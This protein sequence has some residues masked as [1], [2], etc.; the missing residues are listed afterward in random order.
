MNTLVMQ[1]A[2]AL[3]TNV[4]GGADGILSGFLTPTN[5]TF[6]ILE[7]HALAGLCYTDDGGL[8][9]DLTTEFNEDTDDDVPALP[10][11]PANGDA[12]YF[13]HATKQFTGVDVNLTTDGAGTWTITY[14]YWNGTA[15]TALAGVVDGTSGWVASGT[16]FFS[17]TFTAPTDWEK[18]T[19]D[20]VDG[21]WIRGVVSG[22]SAITTR[23]LV[24][25]GFIIVESANSLFTDDTADLID[26]G[27]G[28]VALLPAFPKLNDAFYISYSSKFCKFEMN[29]ATARTGTATLI[30]EYWNGTVWG[31]IT[32]VIDD[33]AGWSTGTAQYL[34]HFE[35]PSDWVATTAANGP[36]GA[37]GYFVRTRISAFTSV[38]VDPL[39]TQAWVYPLVTGADG[40]Q[41]Q[42]TMTISLINMNAGTISA[43]NNDSKFLLLNVS[44][45]VF[46]PFTWT[47]ADVAE[48]AAISLNVAAN[49]K[50]ALIQIQEDVT[51]EF[52]DG[53]FTLTS[54]N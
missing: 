40:L 22:F 5:P 20:G 34:I 12:T 23:P 10:A 53:I 52:A 6:G 25:Q 27:A 18:N 42:E 47:Q 37:V 21:F 36:D 51:T 14:E 43:T 11:A 31:L 30:V 49:E 44:T 29:M 4:G 50:L 39:G 35:P 17:I 3:G 13:G 9:V 45:G 15:Y 38:T 41:V 33:S 19:V 54:V 46:V 16:G 24:G 26:A 1:A 8:F 32:G 28:D 2:G 48:Q 7:T